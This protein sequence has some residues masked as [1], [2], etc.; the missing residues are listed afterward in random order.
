M[1]AIT[2]DADIIDSRDV[3]ERIAYL[4]AESAEH[5]EADAPHTE[6]GWSETCPLCEANDDLASELAALESLAEEGNNY[7]EDWEYG[8]TLIRDSYFRTHAQE[9]AEDIGAIN[10]TSSWPIYCIDW[11]AAARDLKMD[12]T[13]VTFAGVTYW[14]R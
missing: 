6:D 12:Y 1:E 10:P 9:F 7:S 11:E 3:L 5:N 14:V 2:N 8:T 13:S 4:R